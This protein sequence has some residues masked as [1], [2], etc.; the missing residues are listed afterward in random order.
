MT[1]NNI[2]QWIA[3]ILKLETDKLDHRGSRE[4]G[5]PSDATSIFPGS[6]GEEYMV[7]LVRG[8]NGNSVPKLEVT[9]VPEREP[10]QSQMDTLLAEGYRLAAGS[11]SSDLQVNSIEVRRLDLS[12][13]IGPRRCIRSVSGESPAR[14]PTSPLTSVAAAAEETDSDT[15]STDLISANQMIIDLLGE[16]NPSDTDT[17]SSSLIGRSTTTSHEEAAAQPLASHAEEGLD[18]LLLIHSPTTGPSHARSTSPSPPRLRSTPPLTEASPGLKLVE[19]AQSPTSFQNYPATPDH[20][21]STSGH[22]SSDSKPH[23]DPSSSPLARSQSPRP[24]SPFIPMGSNMQTEPVLPLSLGLPL[25][26][27]HVVKRS[28]AG[29]SNSSESPAGFDDLPLWIDH[30]NTLSTLANGLQLRD[31]LPG[32]K[33]SQNQ[34]FLSFRSL[35]I[36]LLSFSARPRGTMIGIPGAVSRHECKRIENSY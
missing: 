18:H 35:F 12:G 14:S 3:R 34:A 19:S 31:P 1:A 36:E 26:P 7:V 24:S 20:K 4:N 32:D 11:H 30:F 15:D 10:L 21:P 23:R 27:R 16:A 13:N 9:F 2:E 6:E 29:S 33:V 17:S 28:Q 8:V 22:I 25:R 5:Q